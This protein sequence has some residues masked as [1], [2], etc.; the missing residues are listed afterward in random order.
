MTTGLRTRVAVLGGGLAGLNAARLLHRARVD[1]QLFE[2]RDRLGGRILTVDATG[3]ASD[4]GFDLGPSWFWPEMQPAIGALVAELGLKCF[5]QCSEGDVAIERTAQ[6]GPQRYP[7]LRQEPPSMR[8]AGGT[9]SLIRT[10]AA[11][12]PADR[13]RTGMRVT[14]L[15]LCQDG[16]EL[17]IRHPDG[18][19]A[20]V[21]AAQVIAAIPPRL[22]AHSV[23]FAP[24]LP[25]E[26]RACWQDT[27][28]W[29]APHA[30]VVAIYD[31]P[32]WRDAGFSG[33]AQSM[34]GP[35]AE[36]HDATTATGQAALFGFIGIGAAQRARNGQA[37]LTEACLAQ[38]ARLFGS[39]AAR[40]QAILYKDWAA[41]ALTATA[42]DLEASG[43]PAAPQVWVEG[44]WADRLS[45]AGS[46]ASAREPG[47]LSG[48][49]DA[50]VAAAADVLQRLGSAVDTTS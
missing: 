4:D 5:A 6:E 21:Q 3:A 43:H 29:M 14:A 18:S 20:T 28:T 31:H 12:L 22:L 50:S 41:D 36:I 38:L 8:L 44:S 9:G 35:M 24:S 23:Q 15:N 40:L 16:V 27:P 46:E 45:L 42:H 25:P 13:I 11:R 34:V 49:V 30:K 10:I 26:I 47:Y 17:L 1:F 39:V 32:F 19:E 33:T 7:G 48:A 37:A 2:A